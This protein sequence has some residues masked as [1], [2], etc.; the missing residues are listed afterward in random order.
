[1]DRGALRDLLV[2]GL[3]EFEDY[4][5]EQVE[6]VITGAGGDN[7]LELESRQAEWI[8]A[9]VEHALGD[10]KPLPKPADLQRNQFATLGALLEAIASALDVHESG[11]GNVDLR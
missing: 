5:V 3:A 1:M 6:A 8:V 11:N 9:H 7:A 4:T 2:R 10:T